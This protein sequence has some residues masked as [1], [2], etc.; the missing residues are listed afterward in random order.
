MDIY[1]LL[2]LFLTFILSFKFYNI[3]YKYIPIDNKSYSPFLIFFF[4]YIIINNIIGLIPYS[5]SITSKIKYT[6]SISL[7]LII[8][9]FFLSLSN[10]KLN[11]IYK[12][13]PSNLNFFLAFLIMLIEFF[14]YF[15]RILTLSLRLSANLTAGHMILIII[16][17]FYF[18]EIFLLPLLLLE[19]G[20]ALIQSVVFLLLLTTYFNDS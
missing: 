1:I 15:L 2:S 16:S 10:R 6:M 3:L 7:V 19:F 9:I 20:V 4:I 18:S 17:N 12:F 13:Y 11:I 14:S 8:G 5:Y